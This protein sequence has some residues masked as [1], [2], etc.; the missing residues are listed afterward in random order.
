MHAESKEEKKK[1]HL[2]HLGQFLKP[3]MT[4][5]GQLQSRVIFLYNFCHQTGF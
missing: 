3:K 2:G 4:I 1:Q 5:F